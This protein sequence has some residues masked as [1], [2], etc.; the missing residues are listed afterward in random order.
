VLL[1]DLNTVDTA[2]AIR[3]LL[4]CCGSVRWAEQV[5]AARP[6]SSLEQLLATAGMAWSSLD[7]GDWLEAFAAH[8]RIGASSAG[9]A[10]GTGKP[11]RAGGGGRSALSVGAHTG[12]SEEEQA[13][14]RSAGDEVRESLA[15]RNQ[16]YE[17]RFGHIFI[18]C[19]TG[20][21]AGEMLAL[22]EQRLS[23]DPVQELQ[24]AAG[25]Q[26]KI[27]RLRLAKLLAE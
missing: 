16:E 6:Y 12:W 11:S 2:T 22:L 4:R 23:N 20:K 26:W 15:T 13:G 19:A 18:V 25:E 27:T 14:A 10:G 3:E 17:S 9:E 21:S 24:L 1:A 5:A 8:P 7:R